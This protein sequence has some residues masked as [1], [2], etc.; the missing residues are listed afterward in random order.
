MVSQVTSSHQVNDK[1]QVLP[2]VECIVHVDEER[3]VELAQEL[4]F[5]DYRVN[6]PLGDDSCLKHLLHCKELLC[7]LL[8]YFPDL[9][10][11]STAYHVQKREVILANL[12]DILLAF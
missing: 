5:I 9:A 4:F 11:A 10:K 7:F 12:L 8:L 2:I 1:V 3:V 6:T